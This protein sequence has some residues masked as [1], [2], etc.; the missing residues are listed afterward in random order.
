ME[1]WKPVVGYEGWYSVSSLG[2]VMRDRPASG[3]HAGLILRP[4]PTKYGYLGVCLNKAALRKYIAVHRIVAI[5]FIGSQPAGCNVNHKNG[6]KTDNRPANLEWVTPQENSLHAV[7]VLGRQF[8]GKGEENS[9]AR[10]GVGDVR[11]IRMRF[12][13]G[14]R[15]VKIADDF[16]IVFQTVYD[17]INGR[18]WAHVS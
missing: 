2:R 7:N 1:Q 16:G 15:A 11:Q 17:I 13:S 3:T 8:G 9:M 5:A 6:I 12:A 18:R 10:L 14:E 4:R